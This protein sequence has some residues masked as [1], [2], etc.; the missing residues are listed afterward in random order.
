MSYSNNL[1]I[2]EISIVTS[3]KNCYRISNPTIKTKSILEEVGC[4]R[5]SI[6]SGNWDGKGNIDTNTSIYKFDSSQSPFVSYGD[7]QFY[8]IPNFLVDDKYVSAYGF[9]EQNNDHDDSFK[10]K[11]E[12]HYDSNRKNEKEKWNYNYV[13]IVLLDN[14]T[15]SYNPLKHYDI[16]TDNDSIFGVIEY[17]LNTKTEIPSIKIVPTNTLKYGYS[18]TEK[19][20][21]ISKNT[22]NISTYSLINGS[23]NNNGGRDC[24]IDYNIGSGFS[25]ENPTSVYEYD[26][27]KGDLI[28]I[29]YIY[30]LNPINDGLVDKNTLV[31][32]QEWPILN[33]NGQNEL[34]DKILNNILFSDMKREIRGTGI[35]R[36]DAENVQVYFDNPPKAYHR[37]GNN[38][39]WNFFSSIPQCLNNM[40]IVSD[41]DIGYFSSPIIWKHKRDASATSFSSYMWFNLNPTETISAGYEVDHVASPLNYIIG[42]TV[43]L[44]IPKYEWL[45]NPEKGLNNEKEH[46]VS[47]DNYY[48]K[49]DTTDGS[50][51]HK[52]KAFSWKNHYI[53]YDEIASRKQI[54]DI[55][56]IHTVCYNIDAGPNYIAD[57]NES[58][59]SFS[60]V[61]SIRTYYRVGTLD[62]IKVIFPLKGTEN[63]AIKASD[64]IGYYTNPQTQTITGG[65]LKKKIEQQITERK[66][67]TVKELNWFGNPYYILDA[68]GKDVTHNAEGGDAVLHRHGVY[69]SNNECGIYLTSNKNPGYGLAV[70]FDFTLSPKSNNMPN[71]SAVVGLTT[72]PFWF[73]YN[74]NNCTYNMKSFISSYQNLIPATAS[75]KFYV[76]NN[77]NYEWYEKEIQ[78]N[79]EAQTI[80]INNDNR[81]II[82]GDDGTSIWEDIWGQVTFEEVGGSVRIDYDDYSHAKYL[83]VGDEFPLPIGIKG[84]KDNT[85]FEATGINT[86][87]GT[88]IYNKIEEEG[89]D[90]RRDW[91]LYAKI[92]D[93]K[94]VLY[95]RD[96]GDDGDYSW[97]DEWED[98][99][100]NLDIQKLL[101]CIKGVID[102]E[103][104][105]IQNGT[106]VWKRT[107]F[108][109]GYV[110]LLLYETKVKS[111]GIEVLDG[112]VRCED[113]GTK[114]VNGVTYKAEKLISSILMP[115]R[116][117]GI[118]YQNF[119]STLETNFS[120]D[121]LQ[122]GDEPRKLPNSGI[123]NFTYVYIDPDTDETFLLDETGRGITIYGWRTYKIQS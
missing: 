98:F 24:Y 18:I 96:S 100:I 14:L 21:H 107:G 91:D 119:A 56:Y 120:F 103:V 15:A 86:E 81:L 90:Y 51:E 44:N 114:V 108:E 99:E 43:F 12:I 34:D 65:W 42:Q 68:E 115:P 104:K 73:E 9:I 117:W 35:F 58:T 40:N 111:K 36:S 48:F 28:R 74:Y 20:L 109:T 83:K 13:P 116:V 76:Y 70:N 3:L 32:K 11:N 52:I 66:K 79:H 80:K 22:T 7:L 53:E 25:V 64:Y 1:G 67:V 118:H 105:T 72:E 85:D 95:G 33:E 94:L 77:G 6:I 47:N 93:N 26:K 10:W 78:I 41:Q 31:Y 88:L 63:R 17:N 54:D 39:S 27:I 4:P 16:S 57:E 112:I 50:D 8:A 121:D 49:N 71:R 113:V 62:G 38:F 106:E 61:E 89:G 123:W 2:E 101:L 82:T 46:F 59:E 97:D 60:S 30:T 55:A 5:L 102:W 45:F 37:D 29:E 19:D 92:I 87:R 122:P 110:S 75:F 84:V 23:L 69:S